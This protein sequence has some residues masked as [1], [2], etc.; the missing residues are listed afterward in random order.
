MG[1]FE[2]GMFSDGMFCMFIKFSSEGIRNSV[3]MNPYGIPRN[4]VVLDS[5]KFRGITRNK[6][7][8]V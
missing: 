6:V 2:S 1:H 5:K 7:I 3:Y 8:S 4:L